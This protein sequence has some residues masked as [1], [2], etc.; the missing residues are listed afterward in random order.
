M[1]GW[2]KESFEKTGWQNISKESYEL[3]VQNLEKIYKK[4][5]VQLIHRD[6][7]FGNFLFNQE[8][9]SGYIDF[10]L[11][12]KNIRILD[13]CYFV[14]SVLSEK[15]KFEITTEK[16]FDFVKNVFKGYNKIITL[17]KEEKE[18]AVL[19]MECIELLFLAY[20]EGQ[21]DSAL[22]KSTYDI[23]NFID[24]NKKQISKIIKNTE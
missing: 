21:E 4:L 23:F 14:L 22:A 8:D 1:Q 6:V 15:D 16:W 20:Y 3:I 2:V 13:L 7:H 11:S 9:F 24:K 12:Q 5:P 10:D 19:V 18:C 17:T